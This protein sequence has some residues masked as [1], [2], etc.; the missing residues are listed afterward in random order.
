MKG[1]VHPNVHCST[2]YNS[3]DME[4]TYLSTDREMDKEDVVHIFSGI[5]LSHEKE[6]IMPFATTWMDLDIIIVS[7][8]RERQVYHIL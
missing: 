8:V 7:E 6:E 2:V 3:Q 4:A 1:Y 5:L